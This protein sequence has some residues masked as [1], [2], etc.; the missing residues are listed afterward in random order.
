MIQNSE[1]KINFLMGKIF[2]TAL[3]LL[4]ASALF[5]CTETYGRLQRSQE[6]DQAFKSYRVLPDHQYYYTGP[7]GRPDAIMGIQ[8]EYTL[9]TTQWTQFIASDDLLKKWVDTMNFH[10]NS[11]VR[12]RPY[13]YLILEPAG[14]RMGIWY[15]IWDWTTIIMMD[16]KRIQVFPPGRNEFFEDG[17]QEVDK[18]DDD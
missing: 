5:G 9:E 12:Y 17:G 10:H 11:G 15:S 1:I 8:N 13:G 16:D 3:C 18:M 14:S 4:G 6:A 2:F 7:V